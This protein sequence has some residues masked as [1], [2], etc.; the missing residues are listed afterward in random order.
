MTLV[1]IVIAPTAI[2]PPY[3]SREELKHTDITLSL[4]CIINAAV[5]S[6]MHGNTTLGLIFRFLRFSL[7]IDFLLHK[8]TTTMIHETACEITVAKAAPR[9]PIFNPK[10]IIGSRAIFRIAPIAT[11]TID[12]FV[13]P[14]A[15]TNEFIPNVSCTNNVPSAYMFK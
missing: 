11:D 13:N 9:T 6:A 7:S 12:T 10:I 8:N 15:V 1:R 3:F 5:P 2:S 4:A 14:S